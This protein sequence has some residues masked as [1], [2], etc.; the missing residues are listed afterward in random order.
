MPDRYWEDDKYKPFSPSFD[1]ERNVFVERADEKNFPITRAG[2]DI[3]HQIFILHADKD[4]EV[5]NVRRFSLRGFD[6]RMPLYEEVPDG[7]KKDENGD[8]ITKKESRMTLEG[9]CSVEMSLFYGHAV[10]ITY[11]F[12]FDGYSCKLSKPACTDDLIALLSIWLGAEYWS[13]NKKD[14]AEEAGQD[15]NFESEFHVSDFHFTKDGTFSEEGIS[16]DMVAK[17]RYFDDIALRYKK[18]LYQYCTV[19]KETA[20]KK[21][22]GSFKFPKLVENDNHYA[23]VDIWE[24]I[25]HPEEDGSDLFDIKRKNPL[26]E[27]EIVNHIRDRHKSELIGLLSLYPGEWPYR[28]PAAFDE[29]CGENIAIDTDDLVLCGSS[30]CMVL[31]TYGRRGAESDGVDWKKHLQDRRRYHVSWQEYLV[32]LQ[33]VLAKKYLIGYVSDRLIEGS[34]EM[35]SK[36]PGRII[37]ENAELGIRL[38]RIILLLDVVKMSKFPSHKVMHDRTVRRLALDEDM[39]RLETLTGTLNQSLSSISEAKTAKSENMLNLILGFISIASAFQLFFS[40]NEMPFIEKI[41]GLDNTSGLAA[42]I[43]AAVAALAIFAI[44]YLVVHL[45]KDSTGST[46]KK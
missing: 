21:E 44:L 35:M 41:F 45:V 43:V 39:A 27:A 31:G 32:I 36:S 37:K 8:P 16:I 24:N 9:H 30:L 26:T 3:E 10:S 18:Y 14:D 1:K 5:R 46:Q 6:F 29:V 28:D 42:F 7:N 13:R 33:I 20:S 40:P 22:K 34:S 38:N 2:R 15:I 19:F 4:E 11:R 23:M 12:L 25:S 17:G